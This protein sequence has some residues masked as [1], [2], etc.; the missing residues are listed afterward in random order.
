ML[1]SPALE[2]TDEVNPVCIRIVVSAIAHLLKLRQRAVSMAVH[3]Y[4]VCPTKRKVAHSIRSRGVD[5]VSV[6]GFPILYMHS[7]TTWLNGLVNR[8][9]NAILRGLNGSPI[10]L[11]KIPVFLPPLT[12][13]DLGFVGA[14]DQICNLIKLLDWLAVTLARLVF[15]SADNN[16]Q[17]SRVCKTLSILLTGT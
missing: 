12:N 3:R 14:F 2:L 15:G 5:F 17:R 6:N 13:H 8:L 10:C 7:T 4:S 9:L 11:A 1:C 16:R